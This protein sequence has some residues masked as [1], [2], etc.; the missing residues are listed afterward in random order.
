[1]IQFMHPWFLL[2]LLLVPAAAA[3]MG[4]M[5]R[6]SVTVS[7]VAPF[8]AAAKRRRFLSLPQ[9][10]VL[11]ALTLTVL[12]LARPRT[13]EGTR[14][15][16]ARGVDIVLA[17]DMSG[18]MESFDRPHGMS[19]DEFV[20][21]LQSGA[22]GSRLE[23]AKREI[24][25]FIKERPNDRIGL[26]GFADLAYSFVPPT[27]DHA[28]LLERLDS[29][30]AGELGSATGIASP[31]GSAVRRLK[32]S[33]S[34]RRVVV[35]F[36][37]GENTAE[38]RLTPQAAA[39]TAKEFQVI[40]HTVGIGGN[41]AYAVISSPFGRSLSRVGNDLDEKLLRELAAMT[42]GTYFPAADASGMRRVMTEI[43]RLERTD[44]T[45]PQS[46]VYREHA[47]A[48][49]LAAAAVLLF[50]VFLYALGRPRL[51]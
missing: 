37:D 49:A 22:I 1:M 5:P 33:A 16:R 32:D 40:I 46:A 30:K 15:I 13:P 3:A 28:L 25:R 27:L 21:K 17:L 50:G 12:A 36:T 10:C 41:N 43:N 29:L 47:P 34:P 31:I 51:P 23:T 26:I 2:L 38:N 48:L 20:R 45:A 11:T 18:S 35:L 14:K 6:P 4:F 42:G 9:L 39:E 44:H 7:G 8:R 19:E 24:R